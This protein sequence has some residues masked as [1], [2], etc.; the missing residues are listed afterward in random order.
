MHILLFGKSFQTGKSVPGQMNMFGQERQGHKYIKREPDPKN[1]GKFIYYYKMADGSVKAKNEDGT[2]VN[3]KQ[4]APKQNQPKQNPQ[5]EMPKASI[6]E[7]E[8]PLKKI[9]DA[10]NQAAEQQKMDKYTNWGRVADDYIRQAHAQKG[11]FLS[12]M[13][14]VALANGLD[15]PSVKYAPFAVKDK[16]SIFNKLER[17]AAKG[18][19]NAQL[20]DTLRTTI[21]LKSPKQLEGILKGMDNQGYKVIEVD[22]LYEN[23]DP[24]YKHVALKII[25]GDSD[26]LVKEVLLMRPNMLEA[27]FGLGHD[28]YDVMK[29]VTNVIPKVKEVPEVYEKVELSNNAIN[30]YSTLFY[31][32]AFYKDV[33]DEDSS[34]LS[35]S[36]QPAMLTSANK[37]PSKLSLSSKTEPKRLI[38][39]LKSSLKQIWLPI[40]ASLRNSSGDIPNREALAVAIDDIVASIIQPTLNMHDKY[41]HGQGSLFKGYINNIQKRVSRFKKAKNNISAF[42]KVLTW[43]K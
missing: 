9:D 25:K 34:S 29:N 27:K 6:P 18:K 26:K 38:L 16:P 3:G 19:P 42:G 40:L 10:V 11:M 31:K 21:V 5:Q 33:A 7:P 8:P 41:L 37:K 1:P 24:G 43:K 12:D 23:E 30:Y 28:M 35:F 20:T 22:N 39:S 32:A 14:M 2:D 4:E 15:K 36:T 13:D 17:N